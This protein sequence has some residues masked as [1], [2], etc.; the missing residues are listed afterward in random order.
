MMKIIKGNVSKMVR[1]AFL[2][3]KEDISKTSF[4]GKHYFAVSVGNLDIEI[5]KKYIESQGVVTL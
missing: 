4:W 5:T 2:Q 3:L 1:E